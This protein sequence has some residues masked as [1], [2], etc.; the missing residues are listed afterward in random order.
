VLTVN[1]TECHVED[2]FYSIFSLQSIVHFSVN[3]HVMLTLY[4]VFQK[5][6]YKFGSLYKFIQSTCTVF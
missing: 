3:A 2:L 6:H 4:R 1:H 5:E